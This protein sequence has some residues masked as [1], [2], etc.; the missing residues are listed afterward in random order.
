ML[1][2]ITAIAT[3]EQSAERTLL[4][5]DDLVLTSTLPLPAHYDQGLNKA[6]ESNKEGAG[7]VLTEIDIKTSLKEMK[8]FN[9]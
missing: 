7:I 6:T 5:H 8:E 2:G 1:Q 9:A 4:T 3:I